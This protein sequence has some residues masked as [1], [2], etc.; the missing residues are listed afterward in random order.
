MAV[1]PTSARS[2]V[3]S[4]TLRWS[5]LGL[6]LGIVVAGLV[7]AFVTVEKHGSGSDPLDKLQSMRHS[8]SNPALDR[9]QALGEAQK[10]ATR[11]NT[12]GP[13]LL[14]KDHTMPEYEQLA[15]EMT[16][17]FAA[18]FSKWAPAAE[19]TVRE[20]HVRKLGHVYAA[21]IST[22]DADTAKVLVAGTVSFGYPDPRHK[23]SWLDSDPQRFRYVVSLDKQHGRWLVDDLDDI[24]DN[25]PSFAES[26]GETPPNATG[27]SP[28]GSGSSPAPSGKGSSQSTSGGKR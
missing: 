23:G 27:A 7:V 22:I 4:S 25:L 28:S 15:D 6:L 18:V 9:E 14:A 24:D 10:F 5:I 3:G 13:Q 11:F 20:T 16:S 1:P 19:A 17:K 26:S 21:G 2:A 12:Y 8:D